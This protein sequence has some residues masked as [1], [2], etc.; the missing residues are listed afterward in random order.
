MTASFYNFHPAMVARAVPDVWAMA[1]PTE[2]LAAH[3]A[4]AEA[5]LRDAL[6][7]DAD[8]PDIASVAGLLG[9]VVTGTRVDGRALFLGPTWPFR[10]RTSRSSS[11]GT[12]SPSSVSTV[13][14]GT[15]PHCWRTAS[16]G[17]PPMCSPPASAEPPAT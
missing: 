3:L 2:T 7:E 14:T 15:T 10:G 13:V 9:G 11:C 16:A 5:A 1:T 6:G 12:A 8:A 17:A 4:G